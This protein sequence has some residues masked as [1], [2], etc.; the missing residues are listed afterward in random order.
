MAD[1]MLRL[2]LAMF[3]RSF[4]DAF[5][6]DMRVVFTEQRRAARAAGAGAVVRFWCR[7][8]TGMPAAAWRERRAARR[9][10]RA[11]PWHET[12]LSDVQLAGRLLS[13]APLFTALVVTAIAVGVG[14]VATV[15]SALNAIVLRPLPGTTDGTRLILIDRRT[16]D[17]SEGVSASNEFYRYI[18]RSTRSLDGVAVWSRVALTIARGGQGQSVAGTIVSGNYFSVLGVRPAAGRFFLPEEDSAPLAHP[19]IVVSHAFWTTHLAGDPAAIGRDITVN[20]R[21]YRLIGVASP[22]FHGVF[23]PLRMDAWLPLAMQAHVRPGRDLD[24]APWLWLFGRMRDGVTPAQAR[25][26]LTTLTGQWAASANDYPRYTSMRVTP[27]TGLPDDARRALIGFGSVLLGASLLVLII[28]GANIS[29]L[30]AARAV[31]RRREMG[32]RVALGASRGRLVRQL[33]TETLALFLLGGIGGTVLAAAATSALERLQLPGDATLTLEISPDLRVLLFSIGVSLVAGTIFGAGPALRGVGRDPG[34]LLRAD[35]AGTGRR[36]LVSR[37]LVVAQVACSLVL[38]TAAALFLRSVTEGASLDPKFDP[39]GV[40]VSP[41]NTEA[42]GYDARRGVAFYDTLRR[43]LESSPAIER[44]TFAT[45]VPLTFSDSGTV[46]A[47]DRGDSSAALKLPARTAAVAD[48]YLETLRIPLIAGRS[49]VRTD[50]GA[51]VAVVNETFARRAWGDPNAVGRLF[52][53]HG[54]TTSV[55]GVARDS[56]Y[57]SLTEGVVSFVYLPMTDAESM[58]TILVRARAGSPPPAALVEAE[59]L[60]IDSQLPRPVVHALTSDIA[61]VL[62]PQRVGAIVTGIL[63]GAGLLLAVIGLYGLVAYG[64]RLR[65]REI[66][67]RIALGARGANVVWLVVAD[68]LRLGI[69]GVI[70]GIGGSVLTGSVVAAYLVGVS[71]LDAPAFIGASAIL[72]AASALAAYLP[73]R[74]A[75]SADPLTILRTE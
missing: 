40:A 6:D 24:K 75:A 54:R 59:V 63:G 1:R 32:V 53:I 51:A 46:V 66:G 26:E 67:V 11:L 37:A 18:S 9:S 28:A 68:A 7:S 39:A 30:L 56:R 31:A 73:A 60:A 36:A 35:S 20:G 64:V 12:L 49:F 43:R 15:F 29:S 42:Y 27:L 69:A 19:V 71:P 17:S 47:I 8:L 41:F 23:T 22:G 45:M 3:P 33:L 34:A 74:R 52:T 70:V 2:L 4:R 65:M 25:A 61:G 55:V 21:P 48:G 16:P 58:R 62:F 14:G 5:G 10:V 72:V 38:L 44:V 50:E 57:G 13:R